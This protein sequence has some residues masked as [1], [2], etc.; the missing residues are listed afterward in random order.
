M[1][2]L[3]SGATK[4]QSRF[5]QMVSSFLPV[6]L[7]ALVMILNLVADTWGAVPA[8]LTIFSALIEMTFACSCID[9]ARVY[10]SFQ[11][12]FVGSI[13]T[14]AAV[15]HQGRDL[16]VVGSYAVLGFFV[17]M[18]SYT[19][20]IMRFRQGCN[21]RIRVVSIYVWVGICSITAC[22][23]LL[24]QQHWYPD[25]P[26]WSSLI[27]I[28]CLFATC[29][30]CVAMVPGVWVSDTLQ[31]VVGIFVLSVSVLTVCVDMLRF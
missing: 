25:S 4:Y 3:F 21:K 12:F 23:F 14:W 7:A 26:V 31:I 13:A 11:R 20:F 18:L 30:Q 2:L 9:D 29:L 15:T 22:F 28:P 8:I 10:W 5:F 6:I 19:E 17:G 16:Y 24:V 27:S 1:S